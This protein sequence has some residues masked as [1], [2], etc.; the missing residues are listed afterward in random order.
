[1]GLVV[2]KGVGES[3]WIWERKCGWAAFPLRYR[4][5]SFGHGEPPEGACG[6][7]LPAHSSKGTT[8]GRGASE[9][10][11]RC[12]ASTGPPS[13]GT[14]ERA[15]R[16]APA[17]PHQE[18]QTTC[19]GEPAFE[20]WPW[21]RKVQH[22]Q[23][24]TAKQRQPNRRG[25][26]AFQDPCGF[27]HERGKRH[28]QWRWEQPLSPPVAGWEQYQLVSPSFPPWQR[29]TTR[30]GRRMECVP[31][32]VPSVPHCW[33]HRHNLSWGARKRTL[34]RWIQKYWLGQDVCSV[35][36]YA[37]SSSTRLSLLHWKH[38]G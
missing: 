26:C 13:Q 32:P 28:E 17:C 37:S 2:E 14:G 5:F 38:F 4:G 30:K 1:M 34:I 18:L 19:T 10:R 29:K 9:G 3:W 22:L 21:E 33:N 36:P 20:N 24:Q 15:V 6:L 7:N 23:R 16:R 31:Y 35:F 25:A 12:P 11:G 27:A 8:E